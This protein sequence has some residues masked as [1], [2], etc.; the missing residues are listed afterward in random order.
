MEWRGIAYGLTRNRCSCIVLAMDYQQY[1][2][3]RQDIQGECNRQLEALD[4]VWKRLQSI[5]SPS[6]TPSLFSD[7][8]TDHSEQSFSEMIRTVIKGL[9]EDFNADDVQQG[10]ID[11]GFATLDSVNRLAITNS[12]HRLMR[13]GEIVLVKKGQG[14]QG[15][16]YHQKLENP[17]G[18]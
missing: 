17:N 13:R 15:S 2:K 18:K 10:L 4:M 6:K 3:M 9:K 7:T 11:H 1:K 14:K 12:L 5:N 16:I 8:P